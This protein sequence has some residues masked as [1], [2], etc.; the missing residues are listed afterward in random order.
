MSEENIRIWTIGHSNKTLDEFLELLTSNEIEAIADVRSFPSSRKYPYFNAEPLSGSLA[1]AGIDYLPFLDL[2]GRRRVRPDS[3]NTAW[4]NDSFRGY[5]DYMET[6]EFM[7]G[8]ERLLDVAGSRRTAV[9]CAE[10]VWW[11][12]HRSMISDELITR[13]V[14]VIHIISVHKTMPHTYTSPARVVDG[15]LTYHAP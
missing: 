7:T 8:I 6:G 10:A 14:N 4:I 2:G 13:G 3:R 1:G 5:A 11:R 12:C 15:K 9:M